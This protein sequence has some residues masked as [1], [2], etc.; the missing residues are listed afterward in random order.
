[1]YLVIDHSLSQILKASK[2]DWTKFIQTKKW[3]EWG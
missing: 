1:M 3:D 2:E